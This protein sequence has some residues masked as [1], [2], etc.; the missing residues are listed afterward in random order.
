MKIYMNGK[1]ISKKS[2]AELIGK[3]RLEKRIQEAKETHEADPYVENSWM[4]GMRI[5]FE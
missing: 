1:R 2:A 3:D 5:E 4:D